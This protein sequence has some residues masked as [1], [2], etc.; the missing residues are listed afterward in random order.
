VTARDAIR[1]REAAMRERRRPAPTRWELVAMTKA[2]LVALADARG[3]SPA[4]TKADII[5]RLTDGR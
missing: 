3:V 2:E 4:G 1:A 5:D